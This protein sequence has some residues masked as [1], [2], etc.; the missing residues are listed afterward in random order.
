[1]KAIA[2]NYLGNERVRATAR[3]QPCA[4]VASRGGAVRLVVH[5]NCETKLNHGISITATATRRATFFDG[6]ANG[7]STP[8]TIDP[9]K[10][11]LLA[12]LGKSELLLATRSTPQKC[13]IGTNPK[14]NESC[15]RMRF[16]LANA[17]RSNSILRYRLGTDHVTSEQSAICRWSSR[18][19]VAGSSTVEASELLMMARPG[20]GT[21]GTDKNQ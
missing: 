17:V 18:P 13:R 11:C 20:S 8:N 1:M 3:R 5:R 4:A 21:A 12:S 9:A 2:T 16:Q 14:K 19:G 10:L 15:V 7:T 6:A